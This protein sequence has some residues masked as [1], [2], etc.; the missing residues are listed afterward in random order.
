ML[1]LTAKTTKFVPLFTAQDIGS[2]AVSPLR[3]PDPGVDRR[4]AGFKRPCEIFGVSPGSVKL[5]NL[6][7]ESRRVRRPCSRHVNTF[8]IQSKGVHETAGTP[9]N[10]QGQAS[11][12]GCIAETGLTSALAARRRLPRHGRFKPEG[13]GS[14]LLQRII[15]GRPVRRPVL[16]R[17]PAAHARQLP[18][19]IQKG[20]PRTDLCNKAGMWSS[21]NFCKVSFCDISRSRRPGW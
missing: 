15:T 10:L 20:N 12:D 3:L 4:D 13:Q 6:L 19:W 18:R 11:L 21:A 7:P 1:V 5:D 8:P 2:L 17:G 16:R 9:Q 14:A